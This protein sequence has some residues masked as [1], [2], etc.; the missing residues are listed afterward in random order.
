MGLLGCALDE[1]PAAAERLAAERD[2]HF[3]SLRSAL[4]Q[5]ATLWGAQ[6]ASAAPSTANGVRIASLLLRGAHPELLLPLATEIAK[7]ERTV[8]LL[9]LEESGQLVF[10]QHPTAGKDLGV[11]LK[12]VLAAHPGKGGGNKDFVR[13]KLADPGSSVAALELAK[14]LA[15][16]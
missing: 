13:A 4:Q 1:L 9:V 5:L 14:S 8:A 6:L 11:V 10:A 12:N 2:G 3:K 15:E 7:N 16:V